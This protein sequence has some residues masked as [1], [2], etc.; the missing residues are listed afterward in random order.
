MANSRKRAGT[1]RPMTTPPATTPDSFLAFLIDVSAANRVEISFAADNKLPEFAIGVKDPEHGIDATITVSHK[2]VAETGDVH[3]RGFINE[4]LLKFNAAREKHANPGDAEIKPTVPTGQPA[5]GHLN[6]A[7]HYLFV[8]ATVRV[9]NAGAGST[10]RFVSDFKEY[11]DGSMYA[12]LDTGIAYDIN[13]LMRFDVDENLEALTYKAER[14]LL[15]SVVAIRLGG[16]M[17][18]TITGFFPDQKSVLLKRHG[19]LRVVT[20]ERLKLI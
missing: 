11:P 20:I 6:I 10:I 16:P 7:G 3:V 13:D 4:L 15:N 17:T 8:G 12:M 14:F 5:A 1:A 2:V 18:Y 9:A 19:E